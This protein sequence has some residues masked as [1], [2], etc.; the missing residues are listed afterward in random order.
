[1]S[2]GKRPTSRYNAR[3]KQEWD[4]IHRQHPKDC[5][6]WECIGRLQAWIMRTIQERK[7]KP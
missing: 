5:A 3:L 4:E 2:D 1:M 6:C 7:A